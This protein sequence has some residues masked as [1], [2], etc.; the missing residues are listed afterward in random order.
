MATVILG[1]MIICAV[2]DH[3]VEMAKRLPP[4]VQDGDLHHRWDGV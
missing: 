4:D 3:F 2:N 1:I